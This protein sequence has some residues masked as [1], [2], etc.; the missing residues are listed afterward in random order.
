MKAIALALLGLIA[1]VALVGM[2]NLD[3]N[4]GMFMTRGNMVLSGGI[5]DQDG[6]VLYTNKQARQGRLIN[7]IVA[8]AP[9]GRV[10]GNGQ[11]TPG[12]YK[13]TLYGEW[14]DYPVLNLDIGVY[15]AARPD[16]NT[17]VPCTQINIDEILNKPGRRSGGQQQ[18]DLYCN[19][20]TMQKA[21]TMRYR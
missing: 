8:I 6:Y 20:A 21:S 16:R 7:S 1:A 19:I 10:I 12:Q 2:I 4:T 11:V 13:L 14:R 9:D 17:L 18:L 5:F 3:S 15:D